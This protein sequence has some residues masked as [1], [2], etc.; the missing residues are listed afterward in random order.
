MPH[1]KGSVSREITG[2]KNDINR[3]VFLSG[4]VGRIVFNFLFRCH[5]LIN[6]KLFSD[7][8]NR[9]KLAFFMK[10]WHVAINLFSDMPMLY[11]TLWR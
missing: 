5:P 8:Y 9:K 6:I 1:V 3:K 2:T 7:I 11:I 10:S 4:C